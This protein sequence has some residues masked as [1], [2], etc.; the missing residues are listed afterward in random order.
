MTILQPSRKTGRVWK[1]LWFLSDK[2]KKKLKILLDI[3][4]FSLC[5]FFLVIRVPTI[6]K[7]M[8]N[9]LP[10]EKKNAI[11]LETI[12]SF[13]LPIFDILM[14]SKVCKMDVMTWGGGS[15][16]A[17]KVLQIIDS[18]LMAFKGTCWITVDSESV[19]KVVDIISL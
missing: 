17:Y 5:N 18:Q 6:L 8:D 1:Y 14:E 7:K 19:L 11:W 15:G 4:R 12:C 9:S 16:N 13:F 3:Q 10:D 2:R